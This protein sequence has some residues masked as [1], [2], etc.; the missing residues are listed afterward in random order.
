MNEYGKLLPKE[1]K[2]KLKENNIYD[3]N[4]QYDIIFNIKHFQLNN[5]ISFNS[6]IFIFD[7]DNLNNYQ[8]MNK[9]LDA[10]IYD[11]NFEIGSTIT[12]NYLFYSPPIYDKY[13]NNLITIHGKILY[14]FDL[15]DLKINENKCNINISRHYSTLCPIPNTSNVVLMVK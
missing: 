5:N 6:D 9:S 7:N 11:I 13:N 2:N 8:T 1:I 12:N 4:K 15:N 14:K 10:H 3:D